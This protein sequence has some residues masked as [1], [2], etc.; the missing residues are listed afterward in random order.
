MNRVHPIFAPIVEDLA[1]GH[2]SM[3]LDRVMASMHRRP[4]EDLSGND[5]QVYT[6]AQRRLEEPDGYEP[7]VECGEEFWREDMTS[8]SVNDERYCC[9]ACLKTW[10]RQ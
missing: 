6:E 7:C 9:E 1:L 2:F 10:N 8:V 5:A 4:T 3:T